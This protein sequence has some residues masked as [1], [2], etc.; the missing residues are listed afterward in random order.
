[1]NTGIW[2]K[3]FCKTCGVHVANELVDM[4]DEEVAALSEVARGWRARSAGKRPITLRALQGV[5]IHSLNRSN[6][7]GYTGINKP[8]VNP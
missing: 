1:M 7:D 4:S 3:A 2:Q 6:L 8:Y 5:D